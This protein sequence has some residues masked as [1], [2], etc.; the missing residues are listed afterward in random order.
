MARVSS[1]P[2][3]GKFRATAAAALDGQAGLFGGT[4]G[5]ENLLAVRIDASGEIVLSDGPNCDGV[6]DTTEGRSYKA[7]D[8][9]NFRQVIG[10]KRYTVLQRAHIQDPED[11]TLALGN[12]LFASSATPGDARIGAAGGAG[13]AY[14]GV[15]VPDETK[16]S[17]NGLLLVLEVNGAPAGTA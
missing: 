16:K 14:L 7:Q 8:L 4:A 13:D 12:R 3:G 5:N 9:A 1:A 17:G 2:E 6:I 15:V 10:G 11:G